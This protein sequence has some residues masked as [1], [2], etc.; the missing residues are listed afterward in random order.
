MIGVVIRAGVEPAQRHELMQMFK[1]TSRPER[2]P[3]TCLKRRVYEGLANE[4][5]AG[6]A[7]VGQGSDEF[8]FIVGSVSGFARR[9]QGAGKNDGCSHLRSRIDS[10]S[11][12]EAEG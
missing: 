9:C 8:L 3:A 11:G 6:R 2:L 12:D 1:E 5:S 7:V 4:S 10:K